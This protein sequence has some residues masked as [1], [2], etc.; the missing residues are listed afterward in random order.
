MRTGDSVLFSKSV[1]HYNS[2]MSMPLA[3]PTSGAPRPIWVASPRHLAAVVEQ[4]A[5]E[6][7]L[8]VDTESNSL[9]AYRE[10]ICLIQFST[11]AADYLID[12]LALKDLT[13]LGA[14]LADPHIEKVFHAC[15]YDLICLRRSYDFRVV[16]V[17]D[18]MVAART[19]G[20]PKM[21]LA[22]ILEGLWSVKTNKRYQRADW[23]RR[24]LAPEQLLYAS[25]D[26]RYLLPLRDLLYQELK[27]SA[28]WE[29]AREEFDRLSRVDGA[30]AAFDAD[31]FWRINGARELAPREAALLRELYLYREKAAERADRPP[32]KVMSEETLIAIAR[33]QPRQAKDLRGLPGMTDGQI[34]RH[35]QGLLKAVQ[36]GVSAPPPRPPQSGRS[37]EAT[38]QRYEALRTWRKQKAQA[39]GVESD[40]IVPRDALWAIARSNPQT[41]DDLKNIAELGPW[42]RERYAEEILRLLIGVNG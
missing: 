8:A 35:Q 5:A 37:D 6:T 13:P 15:E 27:T 38:L 7:A 40:V 41:A 12:P 1:A 33:R 10:R 21:G 36:R 9:F 14:L 24:P 11:R 34:N 30:P 29:E 31:G 16:N 18:T 4:L 26:T 20:W 3:E 17:F 25:L 23:S 32:F 22:T 19:L 39:R 28:R 42:R 2:P